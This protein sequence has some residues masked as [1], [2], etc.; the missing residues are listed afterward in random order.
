MESSGQWGT[1]KKRA[2]ERFDVFITTD[3]NL[4]YQQNLEHRR[5]AILILPST[6]WPTIQAYLSQIIAAVDQLQQGDLCEL[7]FL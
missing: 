6:S 7:S 2:E 5:L 3:K 1:A 4:R